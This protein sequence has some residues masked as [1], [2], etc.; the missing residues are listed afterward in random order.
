[1]STCAGIPNPDGRCFSIVGLH[2][3]F[4]MPEFIE[5]MQKKKLVI[6]DWFLTS[7]E[8]LTKGP[9]KEPPVKSNKKYNQMIE[10]IL[11]AWE[12]IIG[13]DPVQSEF[14]KT[15]PPKIMPERVFVSRHGG[16]SPRKFIQLV[17]HSLETEGCNMGFLN[18]EAFSRYVEMEPVSI[19]KLLNQI[20]SQRKKSL[21]VA[22]S[23]KDK[24]EY[25]RLLLSAK[26][27][28]VQFRKTG[29]KTSLPTFCVPIDGYKIIMYSVVCSDPPDIKWVH[30]ICL[31]DKGNG[32]FCII[33]NS[34]SQDLKD[35]VD[36]FFRSG[37]SDY[38]NV[39][40]VA[41]PNFILC[42]RTKDPRVSITHS[43]QTSY[44][45]FKFIQSLLLRGYEVEENKDESKDIDIFFRVLDADRNI[46][47]YLLCGTDLE[48]T[49]IIS[50][51]Q[52]TSEQIS[53]GTMVKLHLKY[54]YYDIFT[55]FFVPLTSDIE[56][57]DEMLDKLAARVDR[58]R[59]RVNKLEI[60]KKQKL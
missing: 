42:Q 36:E 17:L 58:R 11:G 38:R 60:N 30:A 49:E 19:N 12:T 44:I 23:T 2:F 20:R 31:C 9:V 33:D 1:M 43:N 29:D 13:K 3:F 55:S 15:C 26:Y 14:W 48:L 47:L 51:H 50:K 27:K 56:I 39:K 59:K 34:T 10:W 35:S 37:Y 52:V 18:I 45:C 16:G 46:A 53:G 25:C 22:E 54:D 5:E 40:S 57:K 7:Y 28:V 4:M 32:E 41:I 24:A 6:S 8:K 21:A